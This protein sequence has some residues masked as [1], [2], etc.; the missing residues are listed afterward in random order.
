[1]RKEKQG[2]KGIIYVEE[3]QEKMYKVDNGYSNK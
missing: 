2:V 1:M 3:G